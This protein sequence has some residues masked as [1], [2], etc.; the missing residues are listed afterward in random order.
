MYAGVPA[1]PGVLPR[2]PR[3]RSPPASTN[4]PPRP[5]RS[6]A[7]SPGGPPPPGAPRQAQQGP[8]Q[9]HQRGLGVRPAGLLQQ[10]AQGDPVDQFHD[11]RGAAGRLHV[12]VQSD[13]VRRAQPAQQPSLRAELAD[14]RGVLAQPVAEVLHRDR[15]AR[16]LVHG[17]NHAAAAARTELPDLGVP[18]YGPH[19]VHRS[20]VPGVVAP[21]CGR[22]PTGHHQGHGFR[23]GRFPTSR[24]VSNGRQAAAR[25]APIMACSRSAASRPNAGS[26]MW[27][28]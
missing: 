24:G 3:S 14:E 27:V 11:D 17:E 12:L 8:L 21:G 5:A 4:R 16:R 7:C 19:V 10:R 6:P 26:L 13:H 28:S 2:P 22:A 25:S 15:G 20:P 1:T 23:H 18:G 9:H